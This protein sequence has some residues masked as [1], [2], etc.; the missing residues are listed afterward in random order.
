[1]RLTVTG[2]ETI[3]ITDPQGLIEA[4]KPAKGAAP[5]PG[6]KPQPTTIPDMTKPRPPDPLF[7]PPFR[8]PTRP[9]TV[10]D[11]LVNPIPL[12]G[13]TP[14]EPKHLP[15]AQWGHLTGD[16]GLWTMGLRAATGDGPKKSTEQVW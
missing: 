1:M 4:Q 2:V 3:E 12:P 5:L 15:W 7:P 14:A 9:F 13:H 8:D 11:P 10:G 16:G 6:P